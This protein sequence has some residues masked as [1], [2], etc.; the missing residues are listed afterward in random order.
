MKLKREYC[1]NCTDRLFHS[2]YV[3]CRDCARMVIHT[4]VGQAVIFGCGAMLELLTLIFKAW[5]G[6]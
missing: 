1:L 3:Y 6:R 2:E 5:V 4:I